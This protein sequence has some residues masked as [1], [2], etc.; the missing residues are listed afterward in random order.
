[1]IPSYAPVL[2]S[3]GNVLPTVQAG[4]GRCMT[5]TVN[6]KLRLDPSVGTRISV[7]YRYISFAITAQWNS[8]KFDTYYIG[9][10]VRQTRLPGYIRRTFHTNTYNYTVTLS[11]DVRQFRQTLKSRLFFA[12]PVPKSG[13][14]FHSSKIQRTACVQPAN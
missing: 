11:T 6:R 13:V 12:L 14:L 1:M 10:R 5:M 8:P 9:S 2:T 7:A 4:G 3:P